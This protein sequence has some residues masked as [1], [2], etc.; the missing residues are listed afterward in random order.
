MIAEVVDRQTRD[1]DF[2]GATT[3][4]VDQ[5]V[6]VLE[7]ALRADGLDVSLKRANSGFAH[8]TVIDDDGGVTEIGLGADARIRPAE[9]GWFAS[10]IARC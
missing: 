1:L 6:P 3:E 4:R 8:Y 10:L 2:F 5:L 9:T 7:R